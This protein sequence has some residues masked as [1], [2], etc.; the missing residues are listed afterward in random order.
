MSEEDNAMDT[1]DGN[2]GYNSPTQPTASTGPSLSSLT[3]LLKQMRETG[4]SDAQYDPEQTPHNP[5]LGVLNSVSSPPP[6]LYSPSKHPKSDSP[7]AYPAEPANEDTVLPVLINVLFTN[8]AGQGLEQYTNALTLYAKTLPPRV[9]LESTQHI[10]NLYQSLISIQPGQ[11][12][13]SR[14][15]PLQCRSRC[16]TSARAAS[17]ASHRSNRSSRSS[18]T[19]ALA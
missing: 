1:G 19:D 8:E 2:S 13:F 17:H 7:A 12:A 14:E 3:A 10:S 11:E 18:R 4:A 9:L 5:G 6:L 15:P 16:P